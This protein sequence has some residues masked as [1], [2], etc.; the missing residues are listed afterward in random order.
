MTGGQVVGMD[1]GHLRRRLTAVLIADVVGYSR[2][3]GVDEEGTHLRL[4]G[5]VKD[6]IEPKIVGNRGRLIRTAGDGFLVEFESAVDAVRCGLDIQRELAERNAGVPADR[7]IQLRI[8]INAGDVIVGDQEIY[9]NSVNIAARLE[10]LAEPGGICVTRNVRDQ[11]QSHPDLVFEDRGQRKVKNFSQPIRIYRVRRVEQQQRRAF[12]ADLFDGTRAFSRAVF[13]AHRRSAIWTSIL[14]AVAASITV[15]ALPLRRD[16]ALLSPR[17]SIMV[18]PFRNVSSIPGQDYFADAVT[19]DVTTDLSRLSDTVVISPGTAFTYKGKAVDPRQIGREFGVRYLLEG[20]IRKDG[21]QVQT[22]AQLVEARTAAHIW[23]DR[24]DTELAD[25]SELQDA[26]TGRIASSLHIQLLQAEH[27]RAIAERP[28]DPDAIDL[29]L[30]AM[31]LLVAG[32]SPEHHLSARQFLEES[33]QRDPQSAESW[34]QL[35]GLLVNDYLNSWNEA[36]QSGEAGKDLLRR[37]EKAL[38]EALKIDPTVAEAHLA[39]GFIRRA[40]GDHQGALDAFDRAAQLDPNSARAYAQKA[41]QLVMVGRPK[42]APPLVLKAIALS[43]RDPYAGTF[44]WVLGRAYFVMQNYDAAIVWLRK[45][46]EVRPNVWYSRAY[47]LAAAA[48]L[49]RQEQ[50]ELRAALSDYNGKFSGYTVQ[51]IRDLYEKELPHTDA[52][53]QASIQALYNGLQKAGV[54]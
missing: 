10:E 29:R 34:S 38:E 15:A 36:K 27:R 7:R 9:G 18:L 51:R 35:A 39:D 44:Y 41:N 43:P 8:G 31:A 19:D 14:L 11:L 21:M 28:T 20:S 13:F 6:L 30:H 17:A 22:N 49:G 54:P 46:V 3:M 48:H 24:F 40:K 25:L 37:A 33:L 42:E 32:P 52:V 5:Y 26:I 12:P 50:P 2:L 45:A 23:A 47:L 53:M 4:A 16:Y 1:R